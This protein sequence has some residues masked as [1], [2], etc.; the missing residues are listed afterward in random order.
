MSGRKEDKHYDLAERLYIEERK[1]IAAI[2]QTLPVSRNTL[3]RWCVKGGWK[4]RRRAHFSSPR[5]IGGRMRRALE[6]YLAQIDKEADGGVLEPRHFDAINKAVVAIKAIERQAIDIRVMAIEVMG[7]FTEWL[8]AQKIGPG[9]LTLFGE[10]F[11]AWFR[12]LE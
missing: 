9:E 7:R 12:E 2:A 10:R 11:R 3:Y 6:H 1:T 5:E 4:A 8:K